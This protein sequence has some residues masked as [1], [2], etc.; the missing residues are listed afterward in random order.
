MTTSTTKPTQDLQKKSIVIIGGSL[1]DTNNE[2][3]KNADNVSKIMLS[4]LQNI[5]FL[6][7][8]Y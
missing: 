3:I 2:L 4:F 7:K 1:T 5:F 8:R 6:I